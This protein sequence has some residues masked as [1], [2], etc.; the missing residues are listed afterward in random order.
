MPDNDGKGPLAPRLLTSLR[1]A[2]R[3]TGGK[4]W[5][6][7]D[8]PENDIH[9]ISQVV[10]NVWK[11][12]KVQVTHCDRTLL[13]CHAM[14]AVQR[15]RQSSPAHL[16]GKGDLGTGARLFPGCCRV[17]VSQ[18]VP[19]GLGSQPG[20]CSPLA[21]AEPPTNCPGQEPVKGQWWQRS[22]GAQRVSHTSWWHLGVAEA[23]H[24]PSAPMGA[25]FGVSSITWDLQNFGVMGELLWCEG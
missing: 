9:F 13:S 15:P 7:R 22:L 11:Q 17:R 3:G 4:S 25:G 1:G 24:G 10:P 12:D 14:K 18:P 19:G 6:E 8:G 21:P 20:S 2:G 23:L 16:K 5:G